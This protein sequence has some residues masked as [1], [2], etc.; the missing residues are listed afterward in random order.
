MFIPQRKHLWAS[1]ACYVV[2]FIRSTARY[3]M[4]F[5]TWERRR[6]DEFIREFL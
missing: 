5:N 1:T 3:A 4:E 2:T 6:K